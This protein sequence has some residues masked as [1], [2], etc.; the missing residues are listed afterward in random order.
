MAYIIIRGSIVLSRPNNRPMIFT[1][2]EQEQNY[3]QG[4]IVHDACWIKILKEHG[5][6]L[7]DMNEVAKKYKKEAQD[8]LGSNKT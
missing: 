2:I 5:I 8:G 4:L 3:A 1:C 6:E 7:H